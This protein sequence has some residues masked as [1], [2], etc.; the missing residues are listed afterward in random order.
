[1]TQLLWAK[2][3]PAGAGKSVAS[4]CKLEPDGNVTSEK[5]LALVIGVIRY[6]RLARAFV[7][8]NLI[9]R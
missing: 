5:G 6:D 7:D 1:M 4:N 9:K 8:P 3:L 2:T